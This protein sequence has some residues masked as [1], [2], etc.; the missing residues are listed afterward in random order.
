MYP[1]KDGNVFVRNRWYIAAFS[2]EITRKPFERTIFGK[3]VVFYRTEAGL[4]VAMFGLCPHRYFPLAKG[5]LKGD[6]IVCGY[7]GFTFASDGKCIEIPSQG[8]GAG[9]CQPTF[10]VEEQGPL[11]WIWMGNPDLCDPGLI[12]PY[13]D[14]GLDQPGWRTSSFNYFHLPGRAQLLIDNL[15]DLTHLPYVHH[16]IPG[17]DA[18]KKIPMFDEETSLGYSVIRKGKV[19]WTPFHDMLWGK[20]HRY[21]GLADFDSRTLVYGPELIRTGLP[22]LTKLE[23]RDSV[24]AELG[25]LHIMH[26]ITPETQT[27][28]HYFGFSTRNF[29]LTD[30]SLDEFQLKSDNHIRQQDVEAIAAVEQRVEF[31][32]THQ[33]ELLARSDAPAVRIRQKFQAMIDAERS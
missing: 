16:H 27:S 23:G 19:P 1:F 8:T 25:V 20:E 26:G 9:F 30:E 33:R 13:A 3:P 24:P 5:S 31:G 10:R 28:T 18:M 22:I 11:C 7:H 12:P 2:N 4:P 14:F 15:L 6:A 29:R 17:G 32:A 21:E